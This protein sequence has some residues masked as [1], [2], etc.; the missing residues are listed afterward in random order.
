MADTLLQLINDY[1]IGG[2]IGFFMADNASNN[3]ICID[4]ILRNLY[5]H[6]T[7]KQCLRQSLRYLGH[8][9]NLCAQAFLVGKDA[10][11][12]YKELEAAYRDGDMEKI[13]DLW[14][15]RGAIGR[16]YNII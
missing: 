10:D 5:P 2:R 7:K 11:K 1:Q 13:C 15:K 14:Q 4:L 12:I 8:I 3:D 9:I 16:L 6:M